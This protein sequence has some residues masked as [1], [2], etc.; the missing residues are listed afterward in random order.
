MDQPFGVGVLVS[1][2]FK[3]ITFICA[4]YFCY[5]VSSTSDH[6]AVYP[7]KLG[8]LALEGFKVTC[9]SGSSGCS[10]LCCTLDGGCL[11]PG[12]LQSFLGGP[13]GGLKTG[14]C[15]LPLCLDLSGLNCHTSTKSLAEF[16][17]SS[18]LPAFLSF[19]ALGKTLLAVHMWSGGCGKI[20]DLLGCFRYFL[21]SSV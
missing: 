21:F 13:G 9:L 20:S 7:R 4:L 1:G 17:S 3:C 5:Y 14:E 11:S 6:Q 12:L 16:F 18:Y 15:E 8:T 10:S 2:W 19:S